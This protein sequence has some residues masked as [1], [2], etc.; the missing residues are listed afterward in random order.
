MVARGLMCAQLVAE[1]RGLFGKASISG[2]LAQTYLKIQQRV[3]HD[4]AADERWR[5][6]AHGDLG[7]CY[8]ST[9]IILPWVAPTPT[10]IQVPREKAGMPHVMMLDGHAAS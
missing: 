8:Q 9:N 2:S 7:G 5:R 3:L 10:R 6:T 4:L 1:N